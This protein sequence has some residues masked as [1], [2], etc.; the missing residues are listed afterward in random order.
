MTSFLGQQILV[1]SLGTVPTYYVD[2]TGGNDSN[3][4]LSPAQAWQTIGK[5]NGE[6]FLPGDQVVFKRGEAWNDAILR[7]TWS[8]TAGHAI[9]FGAYGSGALPVLSPTNTIPIYTNGALRSYITIENIDCNVNGTGAYGMQLQLANST[10]QNCVVQNSSGVGLLL[11]DSSENVVI[12]T[13]I[14]HDNGASGISAYGA[15]TAVQSIMVTGCT[16]YDNG[17]NTSSDHGIYVRGGSNHL[18]SG[19][20]SYGN[21]A[22]GVKFNDTTNSI[23]RQNKCYENTHGVII[24]STAAATGNLIKNNLLYDNGGCGIQLIGAGTDSNEFYFNTIVLNYIAG[25]GTAGFRLYD[26]GQSG[27][28]FKNNIVYTDVAVTTNC[29]IIRFQGTTCRD[30]TVCDYNVYFWK[31]RAPTGIIYDSTGYITLATWQG[32]GQ[33]THSYDSDPLFNNLGARNLHVTALSPGNNLGVT[34]AGI[35]EDYDSVTRDSPPDIGAYE[36]V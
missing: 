29:P 10:I 15:G 16:S 19:N 11:E 13:C 9:T 30:N 24:A 5:V 12:D 14:I 17:V 18:I 26:D 31:D 22:G 33:D 20:T 35:T 25:G 36:Y 21:A 1:P 23:I 27:N 2:A 8:G 34:I 4:G 6:T 3:T 7:I 32:M 28:I